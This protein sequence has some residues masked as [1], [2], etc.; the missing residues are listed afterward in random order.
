MLNAVMSSRRITK[1]GLWIWCGKLLIF[2][3]AVFEEAK[4]FKGLMSK[5]GSGTEKRA[6]DWEPETLNSSL[7]LLLSCCMT[8]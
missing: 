5:L 7:A 4:H 3:K 6:L 8:S 2:K 1:S